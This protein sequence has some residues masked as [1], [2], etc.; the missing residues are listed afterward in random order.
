MLSIQGFE[1]DGMEARLREDCIAAAAAAK[2]GGG[3]PVWYEEGGVN[4]QKPLDVQADKSFT[5]RAAYADHV[6]KQEGTATCE[7]VRVPIADETAPEE[8]DFDQLVDEL[9]GLAADGSERAKATT[10][11]VFNCHMGRGRT[12]TGM[13]CGAILLRAARG[14]K[15]AEGAAAAALPAPTAEGR[16]LKRGEFVGILTLLAQLDA[17][18][19][20]KGL[21][22]KCKLLVDACADEA[23]EVTHLVAAPAKCIEKAEKAAAKAAAG[24]GPEAPKAGPAE[25]SMGT[26]A[27]WRHRGVKYLERYAYLL[28]FAAYVHRH[29]TG[30]RSFTEW[31]RTHWAFKRTI[32][33]LE[34]E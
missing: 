27:F 1:L 21:G 14:W 25:D 30:E 4:A 9:A 7:Y 19:H 11:L 8:Q 28:L 23:D 34:L 17:A 29:P 32:G 31:M 2:G 24:G 13:V 18:C 5:V 20:E 16:D 26:P 6:N 33:E 15:P 3:L 12:T 10:A 22:L